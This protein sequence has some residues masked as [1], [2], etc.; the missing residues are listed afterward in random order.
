[1]SRSRCRDHLAGQ[2]FQVDPGAGGDFAG[3]DRHAGLDHGFA[4]NAGA[5][6]LREDRVEHGI[7]DLVGHLVRMAFGDRFGGEQV[8]GHRVYILSFG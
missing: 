8:A 6:V 2:C 4:G 5:R 7:G 1:M 3:D